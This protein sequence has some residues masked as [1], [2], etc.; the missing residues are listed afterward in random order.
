MEENT[1]SQIQ[2]IL[3]N[4]AD[5]VKTLNSIGCSFFVKATAYPETI[6]SSS[7][8]RWL[9][10]GRQ[11]GEFGSENQKKA[12]EK[13]IE[14]AEDTSRRMM[15]MRILLFTNPLDLYKKPQKKQKAKS[16]QGGGQKEEEEKIMIRETI[17][18]LLQCED[19]DI[20]YLKR[21]EDEQLRIEQHKRELFLSFSSKKTNNHKQMKVHC[22]VTYTADNDNDPLIN[23]YKKAFDKDFKRAKKLTYKNG[24]IR[25]AN[26]LVSRAWKWMMSEAGLGITLGW[27]SLIVGVCGIFLAVKIGIIGLIAVVIS[28]IF[29]LIRLSTKYA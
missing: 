18:K 28:G 29:G 16:K 19:I 24:K 22:G 5:T 12:I 21:D 7:Q 26:N 27:L 9:T 2:I 10:H 11:D 13:I 6:I 14:D 1:N 3:G 23:Y 15:N 8:L 25:Y 4:D 20:R 17:E